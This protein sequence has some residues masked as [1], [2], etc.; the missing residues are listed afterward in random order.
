MKT[1]KKLFVLLCIFCFLIPEPVQAQEKFDIYNYTVNIVVHEDGLLDVHEE[2]DLSYTQ[3]VHGFYRNI[4]VK[5]EMDFGNGEQTYYFPVDD[6]EVIN[7]PYETESSSDGV[8]IKIGDPDEYVSGNQTYELSYTIQTRDLNLDQ[9]YFYLNLIG[10]QFDC[11]IH[12]VNFSITFPKSIDITYLEFYGADVQTNI[13]SNTII[14]TTTETL[15]NY[16]ALTVLLPLGIDYFSFEPIPDYTIFG[17]ILSGIVLVIAL[18]FYLKYSRSQE[19]IPTVEFN[20]PKGLGSAGVGYVIDGIVNNQDVLSLI[21]DFANRGYL[22]IH[23]TEDDI[24]L[25]KVNDI[26]DTTPGYERVFFHAIFLNRDEVSCNDL[27]N[28]HFGDQIQST[29][30]LIKNHFLLKENRIYTGGSIAIQVILCIFSGMAA[31]LLSGFALYH[32]I[33]MAELAIL[34]IIFIWLILSATMIFWIVLSLN[35][36]IYSKVKFIG[37]FILA[38][39][40]N[41]LPLIVSIFL[42][43][44]PLPIAFVLFY[45]VVMAYMLLTSGKRTKI[46]NEYLAKILGLKNFIEVAEKDRLEMLVHENPNYFYHILAYAYVLG[47]SDVWSK[48]FEAINI[49]SPDWYSSTYNR[50]FSTAYWMTRFDSTMNTFDTLSAAITPPSSGSGGFSSSGGGFSGGGFGGGGGGSW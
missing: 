29:K 37:F 49:S 3:P 7:H 6:I 13:D 50:P 46:G 33:G 35:K 48:K 39:I 26:E 14:G 18:F 47:V 8:Q 22:K 15:N 28:D 43:Q 34:P 40:L 2:I 23:E 24:I 10:D 32:K 45:T 1:I 38:I 9:D 11:K 5:Y 27:I 20:A 19:V 21:I 17:I 12:H 41:A 16:Q 44:K 4:P 25:T 30:D 31:G 42:I 36:H